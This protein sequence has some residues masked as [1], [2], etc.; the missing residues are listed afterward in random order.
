[1]NKKIGFIGLGQMGIPMAKNL[2]SA[3]YQLQVYNRTISKADELDSASIVVCQTPAEAAGGVD[4]I[5]TMLSEDEIVKETVLGDQGILKTLAKN[6]LHI[7]MSTISPDIARLLSNEHK[8]AGSRYLA[9]PV[10]GRPEAA[11]AK[12]L[13]IC[14]SGDQQSKEIAK[15]VLENLGQGIFDFGEDAGGANVVKVAGNFMIMASLEMMAEAYTLAEKSGLDRLKV[16][17]FFGSTLFNTPLFQNYGKLI[18]GK[19]YQPV[20]F[21]SKLGYKDAR[22]AFKLSQQA[23]SPMPIVSVVHNRLLSAVAKGW[24]D[25]DWVEGF[26]RG[27]SEDAGV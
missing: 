23:E 3:G 10:F 6:G 11:A 26:G 17:E 14:T 1:M 12:K 9:A 15:P 5:I 20:G 25:T 22:I 4:I 21:K 7:S 18:A 2:I 19:Q 24:G 27:V 13:W 16:A 8:N